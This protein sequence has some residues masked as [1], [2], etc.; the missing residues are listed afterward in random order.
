MQCAGADL[1]PCRCRVHAS[2]Q[3]ILLAILLLLF[4]DRH[5]SYL[6]YE[7]RMIRRRLEDNI[8]LF[9]NYLVGVVKVVTNNEQGKIGLLSRWKVG[10]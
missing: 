5:I 10:G 8:Y 7:N 2:D 1:E 9:K 3:Y 4:D 6:I